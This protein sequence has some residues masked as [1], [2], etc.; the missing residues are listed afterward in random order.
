[1][2]LKPA[3]DVFGAKLCWLP[4]DA[5][6]EVPLNDLVAQCWRE[7]V[8]ATKEELRKLG[9]RMASITLTRWPATHFFRKGGWVSPSNLPSYQ[10]CPPA[11]CSNVQVKKSCRRPLS[12]E[13]R[14]LCP[15]CTTKATE[16][17][18]QH[19]KHCFARTSGC[20]GDTSR[21]DRAMHGHQSSKTTTQTNR[22]LEMD[23][24]R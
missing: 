17:N 15:T 8:Q 2:S 12:L 22:D 20:F 3:E 9:G 1:M 6:G 7:A 5:L 4:P 16:R 23:R 14:V 19:L 18:E 10:A 24:G 11:P 21:G 13:V